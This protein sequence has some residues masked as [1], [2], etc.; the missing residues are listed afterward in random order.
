MTYLG[1]L[2]LCFLLSDLVYFLQSQTESQVYFKLQSAFKTKVKTK[3]CL[4]G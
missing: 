3:T 2:T 1:H 4:V